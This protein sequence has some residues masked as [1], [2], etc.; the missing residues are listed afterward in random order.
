LEN[1]AE[2]LK[3]VLRLPARV[4]KG[5]NDVEI[6][7]NEG[8]RQYRSSILL[9]KINKIEEPGALRV[10]GVADVDLYAP[11]LNFIFGEASLGGREGIISLKR[12]RPEFYGQP[13]DDK[14]FALR[15]LKEAVHELGHT[16]GLSHCPKTNCV[17]HFSNLLTDTDK[18]AERFCPRCEDLYKNVVRVGEVS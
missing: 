17:M 1:L 7:Y 11:T 14:L 9:E 4:G 15:T 5:F 6:A 12:L 18:K 13:T 8:R 16:F 3:K 10:L 2:E